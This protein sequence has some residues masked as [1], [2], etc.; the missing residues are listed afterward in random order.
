MNGQ[1]TP[2][3]IKKYYEKAHWQKKFGDTDEEI[4]KLI[5]T[6]FEDCEAFQ[7]KIASISKQVIGSLGLSCFSETNDNL[8]MWAHYTED[9]KGLCLEF[10][11]EKDKSFFN[12]LKR[13]SYTEKYPV[14]NYL[15][16]KNSVVEQ[17]ILHKSLHWNYEC[18]I[19]LLK[20][21]TGL[22]KFNPESLV[23]IYFGVRTPQ[24]Q[25][26]T[27][28]NLIRESKKYKGVK[29]YKAVLDSESYKINFKEV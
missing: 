3:Q 4:Q 27:I 2:E 26:N 6:N 14:Y 19:R 12:P 22:Y 9:H 11:H 17:L 8:L 5:E 13:V 10:D 28:K 23:G 18:E 15:N 24:E 16:K 25:V 7:R 21:K 29:L 20:H 1:N